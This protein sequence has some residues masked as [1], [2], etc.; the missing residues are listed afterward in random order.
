MTSSVSPKLG[1]IAVLALAAFGLALAGCAVPPPAGPTVTAL[2]VQG[3]TFAA[4]Q[5]QDAS[6]RNY[7]AGQTEGETYNRAGVRSA[8]GGTVLGAGVG[9]AT[10]AVAGSFTG[11]AG[12]GAAVGAA[13]GA[14]GGLILGLVHAVGSRRKQM[15]A[16]QN[17][18]NI[19]YSQCMVAAGDR[20]V[21]Y[22]PAYPGG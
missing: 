16:K 12:G 18:Y 4:F 13:T 7:A 2:P 6:C 21:V 9:A 19:A 1:R 8:V 11:N 20:V 14:A 22:G 3:E 17:S 5:Q 15:D 10:G